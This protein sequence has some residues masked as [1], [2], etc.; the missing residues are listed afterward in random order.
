[1]FCSK[2][3]AENSDGVNFCKNCGNQIGISQPAVTT[4]QELVLP[5]SI[6]RRLLNN[7]IDG[8]VGTIFAFV[9]SFIAIMVFS[10]GE[11][12]IISISN[13]IGIFVFFS[14]FLI[15]EALFQRTVGKMLTGTKVVNLQGEKPS[16]WSLFLRSLARYI[17]FE[18]LSFLFYGPY[19]TKGWHDRLSHTLVVPKKLT[20]EQVRSI[21]DKKI[22]EQKHN[23]TVMIIIIA[24]IAGLFFIAILG[25]LS[26]VVLASLNSARGKAR[27]ARVK[28]TLMSIR[29][30]AELYY[31]FNSD[32]YTGVCSDVDVKDFLSSE[33]K[34]PSKEYICNDNASNWAASIPLESG[35][36]FCVDGAG[37]TNEISTQLTKQTICPNVDLE[38]TKR[39]SVSKIS[40]EWG[41]YSS[42]SGNFSMSFHGTPIVDSKLNIPTGD[43]T[44][45][46]DMYTY[47]SSDGTNSFFLA[48]NT[49][50]VALNDVDIDELLES[51]LN[52]LLDPVADT[53]LVSSN[54]ARRLSR[55]RT[56]EFELRNQGQD[57]KGFILFDDD[58]T[59][60]LI[61]MTSPILTLSQTTYDNFVNSLRIK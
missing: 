45:T 59:I 36:S 49:Y 32:S 51:F 30:Q 4:A 31:D 16:F 9:V 50:S 41:T 58:K 24:L 3:G 38:D 20:P 42:K 52:S 55:N 10:F 25:I 28:S 43:P 35:K 34:N 2:C 15:F 47:I 14:Y 39:E 29:I 37:N 1:M 17:P 8:F 57:I 33:S 22:R 27:D 53:Y 11:N 46:F 40:T 54:Y 56:L 48:T 61:M 18:A 23:N 6:L 7:I 13:I 26:S 19:P 44:I 60:Y 21:D 12:S 5:A